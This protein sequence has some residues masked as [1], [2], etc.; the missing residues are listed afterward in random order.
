MTDVT[1]S[2]APLT[3]QV[4]GEIKQ[5]IA[6]RRLLPGSKLPSI[7]SFAGT[8][9]VSKSTIVD[10]YDRLV[11]DGAISS[12]AGSGFFVTG[13]LPPLA[14]SEIAPRLDRE[15]DPLWVSRQTLEAGNEFLKP[16]CGWL[17]A[18]W[19]P[20]DCIRRALRSLARG[21]DTALADYGTPLGHPALRQH[22]NQHLAENGIAT[23]LN[24]IMLVD[25]GTQAIDLLCRFLLEP[26]DVVL[27]DDPCYF[28]FHALL[29]AHQCQV[30]T[31]PY[32]Q[33]G[34][35]LSKFEDVL[36]KQKPR[37]YI[38]NSAIHNPTGA[39]LD[40][41]TAHGVLK[42]AEQH[43]LTII[44]DDIF[45]DFEHRP[46]PRLSAFDG[47]ERVI[48]IGSFS[49]TISAS[50]RCGF[51]AASKN[52]VES[53]SDLKIATSFGGNPFAA[54]IIAQIVKDR[55]YQKHLVNLRAR[56][57]IAMDET[58]QRLKK[59]GIHPAM[60]ARQGMYLWCAIPD[61]LNAADIARQALEQ[62]IILAPGNVFSRNK[63]AGRFLRFNVA[64]SSDD[65]IFSYL[66]KLTGRQGKR[67]GQIGK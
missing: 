16:G 15:V 2:K 36:K 45:A 37:L 63:N 52:W 20:D 41:P 47:L 48:C 12:R 5:R 11:A 56:L 67:A 13:Q 19:M 53:I 10:A 38:T 1:T 51:I 62:K 26:G 6:G 14:L 7:R 59:I 54:A 61:S 8:M 58:R 3:E 42:L 43:D 64:Q 22:I 44:E 40:A 57:L 28:N 66:A 30:V 60:D 25:S 17:P 9:G 65:R 34:P 4:M 33:T 18:S 24:Q 27:V 39:R 35:D 31:V 49:K 32:T 46:A 23:D 29:K 21:N 50:V 55:T